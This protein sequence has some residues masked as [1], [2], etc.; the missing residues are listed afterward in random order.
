MSGDLVSFRMVYVAAKEPGEEL[1]KPDHEYWRQGATMAS[2]PIDFSA[3]DALAAAATLKQGG[4]DICVLDGSLP[5]NEK[6]VVMEAVSGVR[7]A[8]FTVEAAPVGAL[9]GD[10]SDVALARPTCSDDARKL[11]NAC[12]RAKLP[13]RVLV[14]DDSSTMRSIVRKILSASRFLLDVHEASE[15]GAAL[16]QLATGKFGIVFLD[17]NMPGLNGFETLAK[18]KR[19][20]PGIGVVMITSALDDDVAARARAAGAVGFL[21]KPFYPADIDEMLARHYGLRGA[22]G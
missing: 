12:V 1:W 15:G 17:Y 19:D 21:K 18:I 14:V 4:V 20:H 9:R 10:G 13:N 8:P 2:V 3:H 11:V 16:A 22:S 7:P 6:T 5:D